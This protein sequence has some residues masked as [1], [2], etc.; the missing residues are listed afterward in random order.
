M[1]EMTDSRAVELVKWGHIHARP[2]PNPGEMELA[3]SRVRE[4]D[5]GQYCLQSP[6]LS[7]AMPAQPAEERES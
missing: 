4:R 3:I 6:A 7:K 2:V 1:K 5:L